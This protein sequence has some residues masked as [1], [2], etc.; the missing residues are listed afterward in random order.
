[1][2]DLGDD[3]TTMEYYQQ[4]PDEFFDSTV[5]ADV[6]ELYGHFLKYIPEHGK[7][8]DFGCGSGR[9]TKAF[10]D[11][12]Y[13]VEAIDGSSEMCI[14]ASEYTGIDVKCMDFFDLNEE[15]KYD[16]IWACASLLHVG[17]DRLPEIFEVLR[18]SIAQ[19]GILYASFKYGDFSGIRDGRYFD[20]MNEE[21][22]REILSTVKGFDTVEMWQSQDVR[23]G[24]DVDWINVILKRVS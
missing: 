17:R 6:S 12:G 4:F 15:S 2:K 3:S 11:M 5:L 14:R 16:G 19:G 1:M 7:V 21:I 24:K 18:K 10:L 9:D 13:S 20:D 23:R 22:L 8:L